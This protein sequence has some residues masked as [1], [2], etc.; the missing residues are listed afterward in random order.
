MKFGKF[1]NK[2]N[3]KAK[4]HKFSKRFHAHG[5]TQRPRAA[6]AIASR[7]RHV[8]V[9]TK[10]LTGRGKFST[11]MEKCIYFVRQIGR[12]C[13]GLSTWSCVLCKQVSTPENHWSRVSGLERLKC[14]TN[15]VVFKQMFTIAL[16][17]AIAALALP[18]TGKCCVNF[19]I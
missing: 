19:Q 8:A 15:A 4:Q 11:G 9:E 5:H 14:E 10:S 2:N 3:G 1:K 7:D 17:I 12:D 13:R 18:S 6:C 16:L